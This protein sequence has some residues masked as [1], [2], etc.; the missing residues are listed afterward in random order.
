MGIETKRQALGF[1]KSWKMEL[2]QSEILGG[3]GREPAFCLNP[4]YTLQCQG[5]K[6][7]INQEF[8]EG[9]SLDNKKTRKLEDLCSAK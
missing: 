4:R 6:P 5:G 3:R 8:N 2:K 1:K 9:I 7:S